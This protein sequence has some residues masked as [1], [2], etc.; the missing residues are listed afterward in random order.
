M[1]VFL[2][3]FREFTRALERGGREESKTGLETKSKNS[4]QL[5]EQINGKNYPE[6][7]PKCLNK[8]EVFGIEF[9]FVEDAK[10]THT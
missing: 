4:G 10:Q 1:K 6:I 2:T 8:Q 9:V 7:T 3:H 5:F